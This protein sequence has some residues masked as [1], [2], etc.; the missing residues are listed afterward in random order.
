MTKT[1]GTKVESGNNVIVNLS[2]G[3]YQF[4]KTVLGAELPSGIDGQGYAMVGSLNVEGNVAEYSADS[5]ISMVQKFNDRKYLGAHEDV[6]KS[7]LIVST[8]AVFMPHVRE[9]N[10]AL[11]E[12]GVLYDSYGNLIEGEKL[13]RYA[14]TLNH[15]H[16]VWHNGE[17][18]PGEGAVGFNLV[19]IIGEADNGNPIKNSV[20]LE[21]CL[22]KS[23]W[24]DF[25]SLNSQGFPTKKSPIQ[26]YEPGKSFY[27][28]PPLNGTVAGSDA[29]SGRFYL[30][31]DWDPL[32]QDSSLGVFPIF[33]FG[34]KAR[35]A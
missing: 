17:F 4:S 23:G 6:L 9:V 25:E 12:Q 10:L 3:N 18:E 19:T 8:P 30:D 16:W 24:A 27:F 34:A 28:T 26:K 14:H 11:N 20:P 5:V 35:K 31:C 7:G 29:G 33:N 15:N 13:E 32:C 21:D 22:E 2:E 1:L